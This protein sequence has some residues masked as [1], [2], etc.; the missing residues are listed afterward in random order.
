LMNQAHVQMICVICLEAV[1]TS[2]NDVCTL[3]CSHRFHSLCVSNLRSQ[4]ASQV[5]P[6]CRTDLPH[7]PEKAYVESMNLLYSV[8]NKSSQ[9]EVEDMREAIR[10][11]TCAAEEG[12]VE[13]QCLLAQ[14]FME[15][16]HLKKDKAK[17]FHWFLKAAEQG[18]VEAEFQVAL[19][20]MRGDGVE[21]DKAKEANWLMKAAEQGK[22]EAEF[23]LALR[24]Q[25]GDGVERDKA[26]EVHWLMKASHHGYAKAQ[27]MQ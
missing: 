6:L 8:L 13:A 4:A 19:H 15:G 18:N 17:A 23:Q 26:K 25:R 10:L 5:C 20:Y 9:N 24:Y 16:K 22:P 7:G 2:L 3:P 14:Q 11:A 21:R 27:V 12:H 1:K